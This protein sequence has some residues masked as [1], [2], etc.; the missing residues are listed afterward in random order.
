MKADAVHER[1]EQKSGPG[2]IADVLEQGHEQEEGNEIREDDGRAAADSLEEAVGQ[3]KE[4]PA[5]QMGFEQIP[6]N[7]DRLQEERFERAPDL[8][9]KEKEPRKTAARIGYPSQRMHE[10]VV[11]AL[12][13][14]PLSCLPD[15][16]GFLEDFLGEM[17]PL[18]GDHFIGRQAALLCRAPPG[19]HPGRL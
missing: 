10:D 2:Q 11:Q 18:G 4:Q 13:P 6:G 17:M 8:K 5:A 1:I 14:A 15:P 3:M 12:R 9:N 19:V 7:T 16:A